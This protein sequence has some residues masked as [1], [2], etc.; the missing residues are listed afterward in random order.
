MTKEE[1]EKEISSLE[2]YRTNKTPIT[3][4]VDESVTFISQDEAKTKKYGVKGYFMYEN[5]KKI[6]LIRPENLS[7]RYDEESIQSLIGTQLEAY[8]TKVKTFNKVFANQ[9]KK[10]NKDRKNI[11]NKYNFNKENERKII[12]NF[13]KYIDKEVEATIYRF[14]DFGAYLVDKDNIRYFLYDSGFA[15]GYINIKRVK[16]IGDT[17]KVKISKFNE[18][19]NT[20]Y[21]TM[22]E[23]YQEEMTKQP[24][25]FKEDEV[26]K[27]RIVKKTS[28]LCF[29][30]IAPMIDALCFPMEGFEVNDEV[31]IQ[32]IGV[33]D[34]GNRKTVRG[35]I[36][37]T[38]FDDEFKL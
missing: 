7:R 1:K 14:T 17:L 36:V 38:K 29:V 33:K 30:N 5:R 20:I 3:V 15:Y 26:V 27:G 32:I 6:V 10:Q 34:L 25:D 24:E 21:V 12:E 18:E 8:I 13:D 23:K 35:K 37:L 9:I 16:K 4:T 28:T 19:K 2:E 11:I 22:V 31:F